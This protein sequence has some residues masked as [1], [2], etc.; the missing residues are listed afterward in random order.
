MTKIAIKY[1]FRD[2]LDILGSSG[3]TKIQMLNFSHPCLDRQT[4][5]R[6]ITIN[7]DNKDKKYPHIYLG[8]RET[9]PKD[10]H[11]RTTRRAVREF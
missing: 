9:R 3:V 11:K 7:A 2:C 4:K 10:L 5:I 1:Q 8:K 6:T